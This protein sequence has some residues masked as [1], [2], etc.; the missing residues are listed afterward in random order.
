MRFSPGNAQS[1]G[2]RAEQQDSFGFSD[3]HS[4]E[5]V[6]RAGV[7]AVVADG[8]GGLANGSAA[9]QAAIATFLAAYE[10]K[11]PGETIPNALDRAL[12]EANRSVVALFSKGQ[13]ESG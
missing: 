13:K 2:A 5:F 12:R 1:I 9:S 4:T 3:S 6:A 7:A 8:M 11:Q 10:A